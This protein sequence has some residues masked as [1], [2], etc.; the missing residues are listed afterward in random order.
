[1]KSIL[2]IEFT[3]YGA[4]LAINGKE[5]KLTKEQALSLAMMLN[6]KYKEELAVA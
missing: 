6:I 1:M 4:V 3:P 5:L 2:Q